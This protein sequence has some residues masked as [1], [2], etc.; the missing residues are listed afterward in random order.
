MNQ[1]GTDAAHM[2][3]VQAGFLRRWAA[4]FLDQLLLSV[5]YVVILIALVIVI[6]SATGGFSDLARMEQ[7][8]QPDWFIAVQLIGMLCYYVMAGFY[9]TLME[10]SA[11]QATLGK[12]ALGIKVVGANGARLTLPHAAGRWFAASL[13]Y[14]TLYVGFLM[15]A[16]TREKRALHDLIAGTF[17]VDKWA[18]TDRPDLQQRKPS[19]CLVAVIVGI[20]LMMAMFVFGMIAAISIPAY[21]QYV[22]KARSAQIVTLADAW[23]IQVIEA[24]ESN[25]SGEY[26]SGVAGVDNYS[27]ESGSNTENIRCPANGDAGFGTPESY[28]TQSI[29]RVVFGEF[30]Q[31][32]C[33]ISIWMPP[34]NGNVEQQIKLEYDQDAQTWYCTTTLPES[35]KPGWCR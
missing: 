5:A 33:G 23:K 10:S 27:V 19:G 1:T 4:L 3:V 14:L 9:Y 30:E 25:A 7:G 18:Y 20:L 24:I 8:E 6:G 15:A 16:F 2:D 26:D 21:Q 17:V 34:A 12:M 22:M 29:N 31:G 11:A 13:S 28:A 32:L 35:L